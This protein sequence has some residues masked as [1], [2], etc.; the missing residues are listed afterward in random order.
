MHGVAK[1]VSPMAVHETTRTFLTW[2]GLKLLSGLTWDDPASSTARS[3][4][5]KMDLVRMSQLLSLTWPIFRLCRAWIQSAFFL[6]A[7][8]SRG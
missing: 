5:L 1:R 7:L 8:R 3:I 4:I 2:R 6:M